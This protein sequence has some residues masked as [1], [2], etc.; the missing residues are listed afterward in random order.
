M[1]SCY[2]TSH[3]NLLP[4]LSKL[5]D[6]VLCW[7]TPSAVH[8]SCAS[9][10]QYEY[11]LQYF[12]HE[13]PH[14]TLVAFD[15]HGCGKL[16]ADAPDDWAS[17]AEE[18][19]FEDLKA[20][21]TRYRASTRHNYVVGHSFGCVLV[22][23]LATSDVAR[24]GIAGV[25]LMGAAYDKPSGTAHPVFRLPVMVLKWLQ[26]KMNAAFVQTA[27]HPDTRK[28]VIERECK[29]TA[30]NQMHMVKAFHRQ[31]EWQCQDAFKQLR[32]PVVVI[33]GAADQL[34]PVEQGEKVVHAVNEASNGVNNAT[35][36]V[37]E[38]GG[39]QMMAEAPDDVNHVL[40]GLIIPVHTTPDTA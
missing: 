32:V 24:D 3:H 28:E 30:N 35:L 10:M 11:Q 17:Y 25:A 34:T 15:A 38:K 26:P 1:L 37:I 2:A 8:G 29:K 21:F 22:S 13:H 5:C 20:V 14:C 33:A 40:A 19:Y 39:H 7:C 23:R 16:A 12:M 6:V 9:Y 31:I 4:P 18:E 27:F 36:C